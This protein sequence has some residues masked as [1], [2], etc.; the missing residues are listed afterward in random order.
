MRE[1]GN[2]Q[3]NSSSPA[4]GQLTTDF[5]N[6]PLLLQTQSIHLRL[7]RPFEAAPGNDARP[8]AQ[9][10][11]PL[12]ALHKGSSP[13]SSVILRGSQHPQAFDS[14]AL[15]PTVCQTLASAWLR[16]GHSCPQLLTLD[17]CYRGPTACRC[18]WPLWVS[19]L[20]VVYYNKAN[21]LLKASAA[22]GTVLSSLQ[23]LSRLTPTN[24]GNKYNFP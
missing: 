16:G 1:A 5:S 3:G 13:A 4:Q 17:N 21:I 14:Q 10:R 8:C 19:L 23:G 18:L 24:L 6:S 22:P 2:E 20:E 15:V 11:L 7:L 9:H 12:S